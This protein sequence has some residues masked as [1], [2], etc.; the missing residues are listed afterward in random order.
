MVRCLSPQVRSDAAVGA[1]REAE[2][3]RKRH[4]DAQ[5]AYAVKQKTRRERVPPEG[6]EEARR[7]YE[8]AVAQASRCLGTRHFTIP[9]TSVACRRKSEREK[10]NRENGTAKKRRPRTQAEKDERRRKTEA[11]RLAAEHPLGPQDATS[12]QARAAI[13]R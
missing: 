6:D 3:K 4:A 7:E 10:R 11:Q 2:Q 8:K 13:Q 12:Q 1:A 9:E 5:W